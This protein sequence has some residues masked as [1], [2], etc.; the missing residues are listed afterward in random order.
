MRDC[1]IWKQKP[2]KE[3]TFDEITEFA[4]KNNYFRWI[5]LTG[6]EPFLR[7][8]IVEIVRRSRA[9]QKAC[10]WSRCRPTRSRAAS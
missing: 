6:G 5:G 2:G 1:S 3:L 8:D 10:T 7:S 9:I 4:K